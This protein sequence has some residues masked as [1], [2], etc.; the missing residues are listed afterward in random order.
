[1]ARQPVRCARDASSREHCRILRI[2]SSSWSRKVWR[3][4]DQDGRT[5]SALV[6]LTGATSSTWAQRGACTIFEQSDV[7]KLPNELTSPEGWTQEGERR[8]NCVA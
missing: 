2:K 4:S 3:E 8:A 6:C 1:M 5:E 7:A